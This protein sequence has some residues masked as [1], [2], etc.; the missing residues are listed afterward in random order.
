MPRQPHEGNGCPGYTALGFLYILGVG[1][2]A[3]L[4]APQ[5]AHACEVSSWWVLICADSVFQTFLDR[6]VCLTSAKIALRLVKLSSV[7]YGLR[8][9]GRRESAGT[10]ST[11]RIAQVT[12]CSR[13]VISFLFL[14]CTQLL[15]E[16]LLLS[17]TMSFSLSLQNSEKY[18]FQV[19][20]PASLCGIFPW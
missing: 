4:A 5:F 12:R 20:E 13:L 14:Q 2:G 18:A 3:R 10:W 16:S 7:V 1:A 8:E 11:A 15:Q 17:P 6:S 9:A 19:F